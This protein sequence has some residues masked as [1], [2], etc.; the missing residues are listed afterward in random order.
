M[1]SPE[2]RYIQEEKT[3]SLFPLDLLSIHAFYLQKLNPVVHANILGDVLGY[4]G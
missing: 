3:F 2:P 4:P 1:S